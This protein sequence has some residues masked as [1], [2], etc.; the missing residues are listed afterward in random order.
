[1]TQT[2]KPMTI[3][4]LKY[5]IA[6]DRCRHFAQA[7]EECNISQPTLSTMIQK[8][9][10]EIGV[11]LFDR[12][13]QP[14]EPTAV[15]K[16]VI[17]QATKALKEIEV[18]GEIVKSESE[19]LTGKL[20][21]GILPTVSPCLTPEFIHLFTANYPAIELTITETRPQVAI[22]KLRAG[23]I[24]V[25]IL[26]TPLRTDDLLEI[27]LYHEP[28]VA[29][30]AAGSPEI[31]TATMPDSP[32]NEKL[33]VLHESHCERHPIFGFCKRN[34]EYNRI[35][36]AGSIDTLIRIVDTNGGYTVIPAWHVQFMQPWQKEIMRPFDND[37]AHREI[38]MVI[39]HD[40]VKEGLLNAI[41]ETA[42]KIIPAEMLDNY[43]KN[44]KIRL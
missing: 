27:P 35:Y 1:M 11:P 17:R 16:Q 14:V 19:K 21:I 2:I 30:F 15:G 24:D 26:A 28:F 4:Q 5:I 3:Q 12:S 8:L 9:E 43:L 34:E 7:A 44:Y 42:K 40:Y 37:K 32:P 20:S 6:L 33:W 18:I 38:S 36:E 22:E 10:E 13:K 41:A 29:Y 31:E 39:R 25:A 23:E